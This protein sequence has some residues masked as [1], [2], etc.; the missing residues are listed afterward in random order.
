MDAGGGAVCDGAVFGVADGAV[1]AVD[2]MGLG[3]GAS[4]VVAVGGDA[5]AVGSDVDAAGA[6]GVG[7]AL[8]CV[9]I[10]TVAAQIAAPIARGPPKKT[11]NGFRSVRCTRGIIQV[12]RTRARRWANAQRRL[13]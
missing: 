11:D 6:G 1:G 7:C 8:P 13:S 5:D 12:A 2:P 9:P 3:A 10:A 4:A